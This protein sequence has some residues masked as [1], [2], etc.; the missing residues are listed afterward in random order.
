MDD[1][2]VQALSLWKLGAWRAER[3]K[4]CL[5]LGLARRIQRVSRSHQTKE[6]RE[7]A[8]ILNESVFEGTV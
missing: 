6:Q 3:L 7:H 1:Y 5:E 2:R 4:Y 8:A